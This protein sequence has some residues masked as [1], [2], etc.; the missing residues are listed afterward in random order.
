MHVNT[1]FF[2]SWKQGLFD[3]VSMKRQFIL[4]T[5]LRME[6][7]LDQYSSDLTTE[8]I[9][10]LESLMDDVRHKFTVVSNCHLLLLT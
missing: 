2:V 10:N 4:T 5:S 9:Q 1:D 8:Q 6:Q 7:F 3:E